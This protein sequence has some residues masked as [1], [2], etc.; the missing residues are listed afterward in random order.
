MRSCRYALTA[1]RVHV[2]NRVPPA[3]IVKDDHQ[4]IVKLE[5]ALKQARDDVR[6]ASQR[7]PE[8]SVTEMRKYRTA[9]HT[10]WL[11]LEKAKTAP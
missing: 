11:E 1:N 5:A 3:A 10:A 7:R 8:L 6:D 4:T 2:G 9:A